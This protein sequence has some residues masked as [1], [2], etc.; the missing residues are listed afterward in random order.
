MDPYEVL[1]LRPGASDAEIVAAYRRLAQTTHPSVLADVSE[2]ER[3]RALSR[4][5]LLNVA[6]ERL[7]RPE[8]LDEEATRRSYAWSRFTKAVRRGWR[9]ITGP[10][11]EGM[12]V[13]ALLDQLASLPW[14]EDDGIP[15]DGS[16]T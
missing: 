4:M 5:T 3:D 8:P 14:T 9:R 11:A 6:F 7:I 12:H 10:S 15:E 16:A 2:R 13:L 1:G